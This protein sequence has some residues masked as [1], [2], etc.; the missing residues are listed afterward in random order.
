MDIGVDWSNITALVTGATGIVGSWL[1]RDLVS[2]K[3]RVIAFV[4]DP[5][6]ESELYR[7]GAWQK[8]AIVLGQLEDYASVVRAI[9][10][11]DVQVVFHLGAQTIV[12]A[13]LRDP[14]G[15]F[16][17]NIRGTYHVLEACRRLSG[18][19]V[20]VASSD[21]AYGESD[22]LPYD[23]TMALKA[24]HPYDV[25]KAAAD[26]LA[27]TYATTYDLRVAVARCGNIYGGGDLNWS[28]VVPGTVR[29]ALLG[30]APVLRSDGT[31]TRDYTYVKDIVRAYICLAESLERPD[32]CGEAFNFS[33][34]TSVTVSEVVARILQ[35][36]NS[37]LKPIILGSAK[38]E[39]ASQTLSS[40]KAYK[41]LGWKAEWS[42]DRGLAE[43]IEW[44]RNYFSDA[45]ARPP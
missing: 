28:R 3:A 17:S 27:V 38:F 10:D 33:P 43:A 8:C 45:L 24:R 26:M 20:V 42:L 9:N 34:E 7:S 44:Y 1:C 22:T 30:R 2:R 14:V 11:Y 6:P 23:E 41:L 19:R 40:K 18:I 37:S 31:P 36:M 29:S 16:E 5:N 35:I 4:R 32:L 15:T 13:A 25:S 39:I 21:K 12:G